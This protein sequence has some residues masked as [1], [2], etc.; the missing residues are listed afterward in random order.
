MTND[1]VIQK[2]EKEWWI[3]KYE[4]NN[5]AEQ[6][7]EIIIKNENFKCDY[8]HTYLSKNSPILLN[9]YRDIDKNA[10]LYFNANNEEFVGVH[11]Y[12]M[13]NDDYVKMADKE[14]ADS[15]AFETAKKIASQYIDIDMYEINISESLIP[16]SSGENVTIY[17]YEFIRF[18]DGWPTSDRMYISI[19]SKG[20]LRTLHVENVGLFE[21]KQN[22]FID[23]TILNKSIETK[24]NSIYSKNYS[25]SYEIINQTL[26][27][28]PEEQL[29]IIS[30]IELEL[31]KNGDK[32]NTGVV[33]TTIINNQ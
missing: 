25:Y 27:F 18:L 30:Q 28:T 8:L 13:L 24:L 29:A 33:L 3:G 4:F 2:A 7:K 6:K 5:L 20:D 11:F 17:E 22:I 1:G 12:E 9:V 31:I 16:I 19:T 23:S 21:G 14:N 26:T 15:Y 10:E 32:H